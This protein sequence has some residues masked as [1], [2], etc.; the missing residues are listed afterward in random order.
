MEMSAWIWSKFSPGS[1]HF[2]VLIL[3]KERQGKGK[4]F[5]LDELKLEKEEESFPSSFFLKIWL[6]MHSSEA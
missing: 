1:V 4:K 3:Q 2:K 6:C 5:L